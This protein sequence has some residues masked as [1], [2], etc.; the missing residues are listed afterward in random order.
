M[1][2]IAAVTVESVRS[3]ASE[4]QN[5]QLGAV[6]ISASLPKSGHDVLIT[7]RVSQP[8]KLTRLL[9]HTSEFI[10]RRNRIIAPVEISASILNEGH[11]LL[12][13]A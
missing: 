12:I 1:A 2:A 4:G 5:L 13:R 9:L 10:V 6:E 7:T 11:N 3:P 8:F